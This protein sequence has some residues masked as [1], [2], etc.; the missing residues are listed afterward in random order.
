MGSWKSSQW[1]LFHII[2]FGT[3]LADVNHQV[4]SQFT[5]QPTACFDEHMNCGFWSSVNECGNNPQWMLQ[6]CQLSCRSCNPTPTPNPAPVPSMPVQSNAPTRPF[7]IPPAV[8]EL[9]KPLKHRLGLCQQERSINTCF[10]ERYRA[11]DGSCNNLQ[12]SIKGAAY[13]AYARLLPAAYEDGIDRAIGTSPQTR[14]NPRDVTHLLL[15]TKVAIPTNRNTMFMLFAQFM[16]HDLSRITII[17]TCTCA[18]NADQCLNI[19]I[20]R[21]DTRQGTCIPFTRSIPLCGT[22][23]TGR[24]PRTPM[25][26]NTAFIDAS[27]IYGSDLRTARQ[28][29]AGALLKT[30]PNRR[31]LLPPRQGADN[32]MTGDSRSNLF[33]GLAAIHILFVRLHN[34]IANRLVLINPHWDEERVYQETRKIVGATLQVITYQE[35]LPALLGQQ[36]LKEL[37]PAYTGY[38]PEVEPAISVEFSAAGYRLHG[39]IRE[40]YRLVDKN[41][42]AVGDIRFVDATGKVDKLME[43][44]TDFF[45]RGCFT[46][47]CKK[48]NRLTTQV[49]EEL[50]RLADMG[51]LNIQRG[52]DEGLANYNAYRQLCK[53]PALTS[54]QDWPEVPNAE[55]RKRVADLYGNDPNRLD[56]YPG[57]LLEEAIP[58]SLL[59]P[60][61][62]CILSEQFRRLRDAD[63]MFFMNTGVFT[64]Q[65]QQALSRVTMARVVCDT[66]EDFPTVPTSAFLVDDGRNAVPCTQIPTLDL[67]AWR[68][69]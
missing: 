49:T 54:F 27:Q 28:L 58:G 2:V 57:G 52:R 22:G 67:N 64:T 25:N 31:F 56:L 65:Q 35:F 13:S 41:W 14:P 19:P 36:N 30:L 42:V 50:F 44:G 18:T 3:Q 69:Q 53:L 5:Q 46:V 8:K 47:A 4:L 33:L 38:K 15:S 24:V 48:P 32:I 61:F 1:L 45:I 7:Q 23:P 17:N 6:H 66:G 9:C 37:I 43:Q 20:P 63:R 10:H 29:R 21:H 16:S 40:F 11:Q 51:S 39:L 55:V 26:E 62:T 12:H 34:N 68:E 60:T 59:G